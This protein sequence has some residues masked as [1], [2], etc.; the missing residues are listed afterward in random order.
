MMDGVG[1]HR[2]ISSGDSFRSTEYHRFVW[3]AAK[4]SP[5]EAVRRVIRVTVVK[6]HSLRHVA[7]LNAPSFALAVQNLLLSW[8][9][10]ESRAAYC[11]KVS[12]CGLLEAAANQPPEVH[13]VSASDM[14]QRK[15]PTVDSVALL[16]YARVSKV[17]RGGIPLRPTSCGNRREE[18]GWER[19][20]V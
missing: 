10:A 15:C 13:E 14:A 8:A 4:L 3:D 11:R 9:G 6:L 20:C 5:H 19:H 2:T 12:V 17:D 18:H 7:G 16:Y 1:E